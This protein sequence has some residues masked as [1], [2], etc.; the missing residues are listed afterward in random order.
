MIPDQTPI[1]VRIRRCPCGKAIPAHCL[2]CAG[3]M[4]HDTNTGEHACLLCTRPFEKS[5]PMPWISPRKLAFWP[6]RRASRAKY[7][8]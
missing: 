8:A 1:Y 2:T 3:S 5:N 4:L 6:R 7:P